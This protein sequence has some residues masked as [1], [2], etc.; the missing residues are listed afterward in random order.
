META[1]AFHSLTAVAGTVL[2]GCQKGRFLPEEWRGSI[3]PCY[4][5][6]HRSGAAAGLHGSNPAWCCCVE[7]LLCQASFT[8]SSPTTLWCIHSP[9]SFLPL[10]H[11]SSHLLLP[12]DSVC[13]DSGFQKTW[14][15]LSG[16]IWKLQ[17]ICK[18][19]VEFTTTY[20]FLLS[21][22]HPVIYW[23]LPF[24]SNQVSKQA[25]ICTHC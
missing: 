17:A 10:K 11:K 25:L 6:P 3:Q 13:T 4:S 15:D 21:S 1:F 24:A 14:R 19:I 5:W 16:T 9:S 2:H 12:S 18:E 23:A 7:T 8:S 22:W 20:L